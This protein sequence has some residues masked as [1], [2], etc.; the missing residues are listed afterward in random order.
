MFMINIFVMSLITYVSFIHS[1]AL[2]KSCSSVEFEYE[3]TN[4]CFLNKHSLI[5]LR[6]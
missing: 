2:M 5:R 4:D 6:Q 1:N 3:V